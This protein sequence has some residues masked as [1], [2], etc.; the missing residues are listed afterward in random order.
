MVCCTRCY[1]CRAASRLHGGKVANETVVDTIPENDNDLTE[2]KQLS[3]N[4]K[5]LRTIMQQHTSSPLKE[6]KLLIHETAEKEFG[7]N[8]HVICS[9]TDFEYVTRSSVFC[10]VEMDK[11]ICYAFKTG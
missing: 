4:D 9:E 3:C 11:G 5:Q 8:F 1:P 2:S 7:M 10:Q 6:A